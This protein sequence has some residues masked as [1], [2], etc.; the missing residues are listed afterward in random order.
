MILTDEED[1]FLNLTTGVWVAAG[2]YSDFGDGEDELY[3]SGTIV[4]AEDGL[5]EEVT[6]FD[7]LE[8]FVN[9]GLITM[10]DGEEGDVFVTSGD[11][12]GVA[13]STLAV[14]AELGGEDSES[15][16]FVIQ[17]EAEGRT[18]VIVHNAGEKGGGSYNR[19]GITVVVVEEGG[20]IGD[21]FYLKDGPIDAGLFDYDLVFDP[22]EGD[23]DAD[24]WELVSHLGRGAGVLPALVTAALDIWHTTAGSA[25][26]RQG[27]LRT[28]LFGGGATGPV[29]NGMNGMR[30]KG[31]STVSPAADMPAPPAATG[32]GVWA[33]GTVAELDRDGNFDNGRDGDFEDGRGNRVST[34][35]ESRTY[36]FQAGFDFGWRDALSPGDALVFGVLGGYIKSDLEFDNLGVRG[37]EFEFEG[38][39]AGAYVTYLNQGLAIDLLVKADFLDLESP[40]LTGLPGSLDVFTIGARLDVS[41]RFGGT[42]GY[43]GYGGSLGGVFVEPLATLAVA[44]TDIDD[45]ERNGNDVEFDDETSV[46]GRLGLKVGTSFAGESLTVEP[47]VTASVWHEFGGDNGATI[48]SGGATFDLSDSMDETWGEVSGMLTFFAPGSGISAFGKVDVVFGEDIEGFTGR[49]GVRFAW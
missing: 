22:A 18:A 12:E 31:G 30:L 5:V 49:G 42:G 4:A 37:R 25:S 38:G 44:D 14:D 39:Q 15:D 9:A 45:F 26:E 28:L 29:A 48:T 10:L 23:E 33:R 43:G 20:S 35:R 36:D 8:E 19:D 3:N 1:E 32:L 13:G 7:D 40:A 24:E 27:E 47:A 16:V 46:R 11:F 6:V 21:E 2:T 34:D 41:Y 17:G